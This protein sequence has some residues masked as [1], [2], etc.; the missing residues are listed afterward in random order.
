MFFAKLEVELSPLPDLDKQS[1]LLHMTHIVEKNYTI[2][3][4]SICI[5]VDSTDCTTIVS[6]FTTFCV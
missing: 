3:D 1:E 6:S 2:V 4:S 5:E